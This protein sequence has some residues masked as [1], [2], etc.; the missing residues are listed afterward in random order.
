[1]YSDLEKEN[2]LVSYSCSN[3]NT[4]TSTTTKYEVCTLASETS[5]LNRGLD[6]KDIGLLP[7]YNN[8]FIFIK[9]GDFIVLWDLKDNAKKA[10]YTEVDAGYYMK[11]FDFVSTEG[12]LIMA[13]NSNGNYGIIKI[14][15]AAVNGVIAF[16][17]ND[18]GGSTTSVKLLDNYFLVT[19]SDGK[20]YLYKDTGGKT[21]IAVSTEPI[22][23]YKSKA[24]KVQG[25]NNT[26]AVNSLDGKVML[27]NLLYVEM[28]DDYFAA[29]NSDK[30]IN[31]YKY[32]INA[33]ELVT[34][35]IPALTTTDYANSFKIVNNSLVVGGNSYPFSISGE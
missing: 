22:L 14:D 6:T 34:E 26:Y 3:F 35:N 7:I 15:S 20:Y 18:N 11:D 30:K 33:K 21:P 12:T 10:A 17:D 23:Q 8:R 13:K 4:V 25:A 27:G 19:R 5:L 24:I 9:D 16:K 32:E 29:V 28:Y 1:M 31:V 2:L